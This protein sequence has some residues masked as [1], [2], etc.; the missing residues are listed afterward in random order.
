MAEP[1]DELTRLLEQLRRLWL[2]RRAE[3]DARWSRTLPLGDYIV[4]RWAKAKLLGFAEGASIYDSSL[5]FGDVR[6]GA[7]TW[8]GPFAIL[9]GSGGLTIGSHCSISAGA[10]IYTHDS[11]RWATSGGAAAYEY[12]STS[13]GDNCYI[14]PN[15]IVSK[16]VQ[17]GS[18]CVI[19]ANSLVLESI[20]AGSKAYGTPCRVVGRVEP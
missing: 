4:D 6:V 18:G 5:V 9:D 13:V 11:V 17:I 15:T 2:E 10:Q 8:V 19:G 7:G 20:P 16:G 14:G 1:D 12:A 3:V